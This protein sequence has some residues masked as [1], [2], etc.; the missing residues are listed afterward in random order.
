MQPHA[1]TGLGQLHVS[2]DDLDASIHFYTEVLGL[3]LLFRVPGQPMAF[4]Q[5]GATRLYLGT[6]ESEAFRSHTVMYLWVDDVF[7]SYA[8]IRDRGATFVGEPH[9]VHRTATELWM[10]FTA[11]PDGNHVAIMQERPITD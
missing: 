4:V 8:A 6:P 9:V 7:E 11:D 1:P 3:P 10:A 2:T 5:A